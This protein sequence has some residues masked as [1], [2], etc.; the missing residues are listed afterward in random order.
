M[1]YYKE[2]QLKE[3]YIEGRSLKEN[4]KDHECHV[5]TSCICSCGGIE[6]DQDCP[7]HGYPHP[8]KC[9]ICGRFFKIEKEKDQ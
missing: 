8:Y 5:G 7:L 1:G 3:E 6:P 4:Q 2:Q 9:C